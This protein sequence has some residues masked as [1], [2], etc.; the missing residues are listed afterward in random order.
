MLLDVVDD[1]QAIPQRVDELAVDV[2]ASTRVDA[3]R[4]LDGLD[5]QPQSLTPRVVAEVVQAGALAGAGDEVV[6]RESTQPRDYTA[7]EN[8]C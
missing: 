7:V 6:D 8:K 4:G 2:L 5:E 1:A 3:R